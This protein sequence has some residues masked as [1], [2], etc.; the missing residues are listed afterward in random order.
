[1]NATNKRLFQSELKEVAR[2]SIASRLEGTRLYSKV[3]YFHRGRSEL[4][5]DNISKPILDA[6]NEVAYTDD[7]QVVHR[8]AAKVAIEFDTYEVVPPAVEIAEHR[9]LLELLAT[10]RHVLYIEIGQVEAAR[11]A[12]GDA[13]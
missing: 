13:P 12:F 6:L 2:S 11:L 1:M 9:R 7:G 4:D 10:Q 3:W 8:L 5:A